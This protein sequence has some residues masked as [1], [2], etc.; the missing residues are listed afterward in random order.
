MKILAIDTASELCGVAVTEDQHLVAEYRLNRKNLH[1]EKLIDAIQMIVRDTGL[2]LSEVDVIVVAAGPGSFTGLRIGFAVAKGLAFS[3]GTRLV[4]VNTL[5]ALAY[6][7]VYWQGNICT[8]IKAREKECYVALYRSRP[9]FER[10]SEYRV[11]A[12]SQLDEIFDEKTLLLANPPALVEN[13]KNEFV[14]LAGEE[15]AVASPLQIACLGYRQACAGNWADPRI[16]E[17]FY[18]K[19]FIPGKKQVSVSV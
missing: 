2:A 5:D 9:D 12:F 19:D 13:I 8:M 4:T 10:I 14:E 17:P 18:L 16:A 3:L 11:V 7:V 15:L 6:G 1:N